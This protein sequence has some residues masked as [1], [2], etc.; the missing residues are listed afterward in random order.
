LRGFG[1]LRGGFF[2]SSMLPRQPGAPH[3]QAKVSSTSS[4]SS[5]SRVI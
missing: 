1:F 5:G 2:G 3:R 4:G